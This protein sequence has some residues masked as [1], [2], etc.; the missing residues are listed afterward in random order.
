MEQSTTKRPLNAKRIGIIIGAVVAVGA[1]VL[2][3]ILLFKGGIGGKDVSVFDSDSFFLAENDN[4]DAKYAVFNNK[5]DRLTDFIYKDVDEFVNGYSLVENADGKYMI[6]DSKGNTSVDLGD[7]YVNSRAGF[8]FVDHDNKDAIILGDGTELSDDAKDYAYDYN[9]PFIV[10]GTGD[11]EYELY[12]VRGKSVLNFHSKE[13]PEFSSYDRRTAS[14]LKTDDAVYI[15]DNIKLE[16]AGTFE[17]SDSYKIE[18]A[19]KDKKTFVL[20]TGEYGSY[21]F[22]VFE[23]GKFKEFGDRCK[24]IDIEENEESGQK[25]LECEGEDDTT[26]IRGGE[27]TDFKT[28]GYGERYYVYDENHYANYRSDDNQ[29]DIYVDGNKTDTVDCDYSPSLDYAGYSV[30]G[31][32]NVT[33]YGIDGKKIYSLTGTNS[34]ELSGL[35]VNENIIVRNGKEDYTSRYTLVNKSGETI[36]SKYYSI[37]SRGD[38]Y[39]A[40]IYNSDTYDLLD[41]SGTAILSGYKGYEVTSD[42]KIIVA[43]DNDDKYHL[44]DVANKTVTTE[45]SERPNYYEDQYLRVAGDDKVSYYTIEGKL[46]YEYNK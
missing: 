40:R 29:L 24:D 36:S 23:N 25:Y 28:S 11:D 44:V 32:D 18:D 9:T 15:L 46:F 39:S 14:V 6:I 8:Y 10:I 3:I 16:V 22:A 26:L 31:K 7:S 12:N 13:D 30:R 43:R 5:G 20:R 41:K 19:T 21:K 17:T 33:L 42:K 45:F 34:G 4:S 35:D 37:A 38:Y 27:V 2:L 1:I